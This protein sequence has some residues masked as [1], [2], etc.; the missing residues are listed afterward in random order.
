MRLPSSKLIALFIV[1]FA[2]I[3]V[4]IIVTRGKTPPNPQSTATQPTSTTNPLLVVIQN[5]TSTLSGTLDNFKPLT[6][7][8]NATKILVSGTSTLPSWTTTDTISRE[9]FTEYLRAK[10]NG[11][12]IDQ[13]WQ[14]QTVQ[15][16]INKNIANIVYK[17]YT[18]KDLAISVTETTNS[19][20]TYGNLLAEIL[21]T[22]T[23][24]TSDEI[25]IITTAMESQDTA[26]LAELDVIIRGYKELIRNLLSVSVPQSASTPHLALV[27]NLQKLVTNIEAMKFIVEDSFQGMISVIEHR[28]NATAVSITLQT[29]GKYFTEKGISYE[30]GNSGYMFQSGI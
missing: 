4:T 24:A 10:S 21:L 13:T 25:T 20:K 26:K 6:T 18:T 23:Q 8:D 28:K 5:S 14:D 29:F 11:T 16:V 2:L 22:E 12:D 3:V 27:N 15:N 9:F 7:A 1:C 19:I 30:Q 17:Q